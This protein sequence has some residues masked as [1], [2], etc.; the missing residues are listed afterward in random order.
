MISSRSFSTDTETTTDYL[1]ARSPKVTRHPRWSLLSP[2]DQAIWHDRDAGWS[3]A[4]LAR[5]YGKSREGIRYRLHQAQRILDGCTPQ[6]TSTPVYDLDRVISALRRWHQDKGTWPT[7]RAWTDAGQQ[8]TAATVLHHAGNWKNA[9]QLAA[10]R[11]ANG[12]YSKILALSIDEAAQKWHL[13]PRTI[14]RQIRLGMIPAQR[15][16]HQW[17]IIVS[18][19]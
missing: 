1:L 14:H 12:N 15:M 9:L 18:R 16:G 19:Y 13:S 5:K 8:P 2:E 6:S 3:L 4:E 17:F 10:G 11:G 7:R